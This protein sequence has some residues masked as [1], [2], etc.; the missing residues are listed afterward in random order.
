M[1]YARGLHARLV[2]EH[3]RRSGEHGGPG[4]YQRDL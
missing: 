1:R 4:R 3:H 2:R